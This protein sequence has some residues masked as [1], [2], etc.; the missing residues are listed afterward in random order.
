VNT[1]ATVG[2]IFEVSFWVFDQQSPARNAT[3]V[4][5]VVIVEPCDPGRTYC[6]VDQVRELSRFTTFITVPLSRNFSSSSIQVHFLRDRLALA[7]PKA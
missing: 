3:A 7:S 4:R 2:S 6:A 1:A 5:T